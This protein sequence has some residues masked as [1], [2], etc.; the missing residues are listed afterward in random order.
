MVTIYSTVFFMFIACSEIFSV[1][2]SIF[3]SRRETFLYVDLGDFF[4]LILQPLFKSIGNDNDEFFFSQWYQRLQVKKDGG[5]NAIILDYNGGLT[6][7]ILNQ[8]VTRRKPKG[9]KTTVIS[10]F[11]FDTEKKD[12]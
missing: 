6:V 1:V 8:A 11:G 12:K 5:K 10:L 3:H 7:D 9:R 2:S 4:P